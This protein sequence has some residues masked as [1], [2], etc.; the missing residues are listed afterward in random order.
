MMENVLIKPRIINFEHKCIFWKLDAANGILKF[1]PKCRSQHDIEVLN[2]ARTKVSNVNG[3]IT[4]LTTNM[5]I[6]KPGAH[7]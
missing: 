1:G 3:D 4:I 7:K 2:L 6:P 5:E